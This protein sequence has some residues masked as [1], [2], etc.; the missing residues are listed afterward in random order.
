M[1]PPLIKSDLGIANAA[2]ERRA[3]DD[4]YLIFNLTTLFVFRMTQPSIFKHY[5]K[6]NFCQL[7][8]ENLIA[9]F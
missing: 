8:D 2:L 5:R 6:V 7:F 9:F 4:S 1:F 3:P